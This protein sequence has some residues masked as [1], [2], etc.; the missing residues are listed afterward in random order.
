MDIVELQRRAHDTAVKKGWWSEPRSFAEMVSLLHSE[1]S[2]ALEEYRMGKRLDEVY[3]TN[4][5]PKG[6]P[7]ELADLMIRLADTCEALQIPLTQAVSIKLT[8]NET[9]EYRHGGK[10]L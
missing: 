8:Y 9:R 6:V 2:E 4:G 1:I 7:I 5:E 10:K 3:Y